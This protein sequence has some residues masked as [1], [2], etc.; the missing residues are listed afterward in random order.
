ELPE[1]DDSTARDIINKNPLLKNL[2][3]QSHVKEM[4][5]ERVGDFE[6]DPNAAHRAAQVLEHIEQYDGDGNRIA[7]KDIGNG[8]INGFSKDGE[9]YDGTG[10]GRLREFGKYGCERLK[11]KIRDSDNA[12][13]A[14]DA[15]AR[16][17]AL[18]IHWGRPDSDKR[19]A[20]H[21]AGSS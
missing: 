10:A 14:K 7:S 15:R 8:E 19:R 3:N 18:R 9:A 16:A 20:K 6:N 12:A 2:G 21:I 4:L 1:G 17:E 13:D 11:G 5:K